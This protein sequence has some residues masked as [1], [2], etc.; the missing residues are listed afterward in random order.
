MI[1]QFSDHMRPSLIVAREPI[2][3]SSVNNKAIK[4]AGKMLIISST[5]LFTFVKFD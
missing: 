4:L 1:Q 5:S 2:E 3:G